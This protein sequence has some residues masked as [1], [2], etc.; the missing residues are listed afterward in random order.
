MRV[1]AK[2]TVSLRKTTSASNFS[3]FLSGADL[4]QVLSKC[5]WTKKCHGG[6]CAGRRYRGRICLGVT[7]TDLAKF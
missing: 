2:V 3:R 6:N 5:Y 1:G 4:L 7:F